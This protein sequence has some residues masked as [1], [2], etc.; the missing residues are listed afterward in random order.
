MVLADATAVEVPWVPRSVFTDRRLQN[1]ETPAVED[2]TDIHRSPDTK[3]EALL[4]CHKFLDS[5]FE[6]YDGSTFVDSVNELAPQVITTVYNSARTDEYRKARSR[7]VLSYSEERLE[8]DCIHLS[9]LM[10]ASGDDGET[11]F[12]NEPQSDVFLDFQGLEGVVADDHGEE[13][14]DYWSPELEL[15]VDMFENG[16]TYQRKALRLMIEAMKYKRQGLAIPRS[17]QTEI[18]NVRRRVLKMGW[19]LDVRLLG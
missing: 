15:I 5:H 1:E 12:Y 10:G 17:L 16:D 14:T 3:Q 19:K 8:Y 6:D 9:R 4:R 2:I 13:E 7:K 11:M 18:T